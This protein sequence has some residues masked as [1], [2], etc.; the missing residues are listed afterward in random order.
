MY[1]VQGVANQREAIACAFRW[2]ALDRPPAMTVREIYRRRPETR[3]ASSHVWL[4]SLNCELPTGAAGTLSWQ[5]ENEDVDDV[6]AHFVAVTE[7]FASADPTSLTIQEIE[8]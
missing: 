6:K 4:V 3:A 8:P 7:G 1:E 5:E 2:L